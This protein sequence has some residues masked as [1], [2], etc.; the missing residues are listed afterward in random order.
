MDV[1]ELGR[2]EETGAYDAI[3]CMEVLEHVTDPLPLLA[4]FD[5]LLA[6]DGTVVISVPIE[7][8]LARARE[9]AR[10]PRRGLAAD[11]RLP[12]HLELHAAG[13]GDEPVCHVETTHRTPGVPGRWTPLSR[14]QGVQLAGAASPG[15]VQVRS[16][17]DDDLAVQLARPAVRRPSLVRRTTANVA[18]R[19][20]PVRLPRVAVVSDLR[21]ER[22]HAMDL[23]AEMLLVNVGMTETR[24]VDAIGVRPDLTRRFTRLPLLGGSARAHTADRIL[25]RVWDYPRW[26]RSRAADFDLFHIIDH[27]YAHL[28]THLPAGRSIVTCHDLDAFR[29]VLDGSAT[30][31]VVERALGRRLLAGMQAARK[32]L[33]VSAATRDGL[34][35]AAA[36]P[37]ERTVVVPNG[38]HAS[39]SPRP[40]PAADREAASLLGPP[41]GH[42]RRA[43]PRRQY[44]SAQAHRRAAPRRRGA[45]R[46]GSARSADSSRRLPD[47]KP[48]AACRQAGSRRPHHG[49]AV[50][51]LETCSRLSID[52]PRCFCKPRIA[53]GSV[54]PLPR[55]WPVA[56]RSSRATCPLFVKLAATATTYCPAGDVERWRAATALLLEERAN[57]SGRWGA[58]QAEGLA[59]ARRFDWQTHARAT[60]DI[61][62]EVISSGTSVPA[63]SRRA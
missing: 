61:Y 48:A 50:R 38:V 2:A 30:G 41:D 47:G 49:V 45:A 59:W 18:F 52:A 19:W 44:D 36:I 12:R 58:R 54:C 23:V 33:C 24:V 31:S 10:S 34:V 11:R 27:S 42:D 14:S 20:E 9:A 15:G 28:A 21:E 63:A 39:Y 4:D 8:G 51:R 37:A 60:M 35:S 56:R 17:E 1:T 13:A 40:E 7:T 3:F 16:R 62:R 57:D 43:A 32:I 53:K 46:E 29:G 22:W 5:R 55:P 26:L 25:N 6:P